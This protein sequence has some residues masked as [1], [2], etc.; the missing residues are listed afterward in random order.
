MSRKKAISSPRQRDCRAEALVRL[1]ERWEEEND[2][3]FEPEGEPKVSP[4]IKSARMLA[5]L[6]ASGNEDARAFV[7]LH[8]SIS[9]QDQIVLSWEEIAYAAGI[10]SLRLLEVA[11]SASY[12]F[13][14]A[15]TKLLIANS[16]RKVVKA[17]VKA[18]TD[19][20]PI[21]ADTPVGR[22]VVGKTNGDVRAMELFGKMSGL[23]PIPKGAQ[24]AIQ[25]INTQPNEDDKPSGHAVWMEAEERLQRIQDA[26]E[27]KRLP[28]PPMEHVPIGGSLDAMQA[29]TADILVERDDVQR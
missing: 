15:Q 17:A 9:K 29:A 28:S 26:I 1:R 5:A 22:V 20:V 8:D 16:M 18:A 3:P 23:V 24:I 21:V 19:Q 11:V 25:N 2:T 10:G 14:Q 27:P 4:L 7:E 6:R 13:N 12:E